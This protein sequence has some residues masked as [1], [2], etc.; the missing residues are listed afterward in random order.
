[1]HAWSMHQAYGMLVYR[2]VSPRIKFAGAHL[3][4][5]YRGILKYLLD[6]SFLSGRFAFSWTFSNE[7]LTVSF[8]FFYVWTEMQS[9]PVWL[10][11][12]VRTGLILPGQTDGNL[13]KVLPGGSS[14]A[15]NVSFTGP[16]PTDPK[17]GIRRFVHMFMQCIA[18][19]IVMEG[20]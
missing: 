13:L 7:C 1:M 17:T 2:R 14:Q 20:L 8:L 16:D 3:N 6:Y 18:I 15:R 11:A 10:V 12:A 9:Q 5:C 4:T 19:A